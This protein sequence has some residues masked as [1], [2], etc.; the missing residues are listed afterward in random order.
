MQTARAAALVLVFIS[1]GIGAA[2][3]VE[4]FPSESGPTFV[5]GSGLDVVIDGSP[6]AFS[7][8]SCPSCWVWWWDSF[9]V[10]S[11]G[12]VEQTSFGSYAW[13]GTESDDHIFDPPLLYLDFPLE[14]GKSWVSSA[15][16]RVYF[17]DSDSLTLFGSVIGEQII[18]VP[19]G[20]FEVYEVSLYYRYQNDHT[21][22]NWKTLYLH[23]QL[24]PVGDLTSW[25]GVVPTETSTW[26][27]VKALYR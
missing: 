9:R 16:E 26:G 3:G 13:S 25:T 5:Y 1:I 12:D 4:Y 11:N 18:D 7:R 19:A 14:T 24:G 21:R 20:Q 27:G 15:L 6:A 8:V 22:D 10:N 2:Y 17:A 23:R